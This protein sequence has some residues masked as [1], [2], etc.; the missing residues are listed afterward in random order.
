MKKLIKW[1]FCHILNYHDWSSLSIEWD[2]VKV[3]CKHCG[4]MSKIK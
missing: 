1:I 2:Y 3:Y 4:K